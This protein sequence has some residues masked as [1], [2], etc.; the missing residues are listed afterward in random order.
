MKEKGHRYVPAVRNG[1]FE[2]RVHAVKEG[3][4][5]CT[6]SMLFSSL[7]ARLACRH[8]KQLAPPSSPDIPLAHSR[9]L[10]I[11]WVG[12]ATLLIQVGGFNILTDPIFGN[13]SF[14]Y[15][16]IVRPGIA[17]DMLPPL[18]AVIISHNHYDHLEM[19]S[20][21]AL[22]RRD[23]AHFFVPQGDKALFDAHA[24]GRTTE[25]TWWHHY[26]IKIAN[27]T[28]NTCS[29]LRLTFL[30]AVHWTQRGLFDRNRSL[31]GSWMIE[32]GDTCVYFAGD[33]AYGQ[34]FGNIARE[35]PSIDVA[36]IPIGPC[37]PREFMR[38]AHMNAVEAGQAFL[39]LGAHHLVPTHWGTFH[40]G[41]EDPML[42]LVRLEEWW[43][44]NSA[45]CC[46]KNM[47]VPAVGQ[48]ATF[49]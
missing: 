11:T 39:A 22:A 2:C 9:D 5:L 21:R 13:A 45:S 33:T 47:H 43:H 29:S 42:P 16:R 14:L 36:I 3:F 46:H 30:P 18:D 4:L 35:F 37:E 23:N 38:H 41:N 20:V 24:I 6:A 31:W 15:P 25:C 19:A 26:E 40:F 27:D 28:S 1:R 8:S 48:R 32:C 7:L 44:E 49:P 12:H 17:R 10:V 34:H